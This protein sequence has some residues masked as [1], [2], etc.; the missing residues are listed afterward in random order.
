[1]SE[2]TQKLPIAKTF[3]VSSTLP[4][5]DSPVV[6]EQRPIPGT[7][8]TKTHTALVAARPV[9]PVE[10]ATETTIA[11]KQKSLSSKKLKNEQKKIM[12]LHDRCRQL[13]N[14]LFWQ[15]QIAAHCLGFTSAIKGEGK[16]FLAAM[17][18]RALAA[19]STRSVLLVECTWDQ[20]QFHSLFKC[21]ARPGLAELL[22]GECGVEEALHPVQHN[23]IVVTAGDGSHDA[24]KLLQLLRQRGL[25]NVFGSKY[26]GDLFI[27]DLP[28]V[29][30]TPYGVLAAELAETLC[31]VVRAGITSE[32]M[33]A[34][35]HQQ[36]KHLS[37]QGVLLNE[38]E[39]KI[40]R[41][42]R[43]LL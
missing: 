21:A 9:L 23:L 19:D 34:E 42:I 33:I 1:M 3:V 36:L 22:R 10:V 25:Q 35:A 37:V 41:W 20:P 12:A 13:G 29:L 43:Q 14:T 27:L 40:P 39:S 4:K 28:A 24:V 32:M 18:A 15:K 8:G 16:T 6:E 30:T 31:I 38:V 26:A 11:T 17:M 2:D 7:N 5:E